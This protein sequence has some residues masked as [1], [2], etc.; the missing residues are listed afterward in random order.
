MTIT[1]VIFI[2][3]INKWIAKHLDIKIT[4]LNGDLDQEVFMEIHEDLRHMYS[5]NLVYK[6]KKA[7]YGLKHASRAWYIKIDNLQ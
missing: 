4:F 3:T 1:I 2:A 7:L 5:G 6:L